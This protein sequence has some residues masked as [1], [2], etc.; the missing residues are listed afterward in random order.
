LSLPGG[1]RFAKR[2]ATV[3]L[4]HLD[5]WITPDKAGH[6]KD[7]DEAA[8]ALAAGHNTRAQLDTARVAGLE[9]LDNF[10]DLFLRV[11]DWTSWRPPLDWGALNLP[12]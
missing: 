6:W 10:D 11:G 5:L 4:S 9:I 7:E 12:F 2:G 1:C 3:N 8:A